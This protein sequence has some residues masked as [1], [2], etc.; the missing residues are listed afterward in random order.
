MKT[1]GNTR[2]DSELKIRLSKE[3]KINIQRLADRGYSGNLSR[4]I[5]QKC[6]YEAKESQY[7]LT[8]QIATWNYINDLHRLIEEAGT[9]QM[10]KSLSTIQDTYLKTQEDQCHEQTE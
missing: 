4:Y 8:Q 9:E 3:E 7:Y 2:K 5:L 1:T 10:K 6:L